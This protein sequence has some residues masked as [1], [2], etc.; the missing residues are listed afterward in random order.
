VRVSLADIRFTALNPTASILLEECTRIRCEGIPPT[1]AFPLIILIIIISFQ[2]LVVEVTLGYFEV[3]GNSR[4]VGATEYD[5]AGSTTV[6]ALT[7]IV[8]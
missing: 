7:A 2:I 6:V 1:T 3:S 4:Y 8:G 5:S